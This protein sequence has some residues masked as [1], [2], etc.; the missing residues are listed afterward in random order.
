MML[1]D[2]RRGTLPGVFHIPGLARN[3][4]YVSTMS[5]VG[6]QTVFEKD[7]CK[8]VRGAMVLMQVIRIR[9]LYKLLWKKIVIVFIRWLILR[10]MIC[11]H[12]WPTTPCCGI[13]DLDT[14]MKREFMLCIVKV[15]SKLF[16]IVHLNL[17]F[18]NILFMVKKT[19]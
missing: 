13:D 3:L 10:P 14:S 2:G 7:T 9:I 17:I 19:V 8:M 4:I 18:V 1:K 15:W 16:L 6:V 11:Y 12:V 5:D